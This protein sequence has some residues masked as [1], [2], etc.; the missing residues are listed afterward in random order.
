MNDNIAKQALARY[1]AAYDNTVYT[2]L[3][4]RVIRDTVGSD[5]D[6]ELHAGDTAVV[7]FMNVLIDTCL[8]CC[9]SSQHAGAH[10]LLARAAAWMKLSDKTT[11]TVHRYLLTFQQTGINA[12]DDFAAIAKALTRTYV[13]QQAIGE[14]SAYANGVHSWQGRTA[15]HLLVAAEYLAKSAELLLDQYD[16]NAYLREKLQHGLNRI[17]NALYEGVRHSDK[18]ERFD[19]N[20]MY[21]PTGEDAS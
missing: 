10:I 21:F 13:G 16:N 18:P 1:H 6:L 4:Q 9:G 11:D 2:G 3:R 5:A 12:A 19:F 7:D 14:A 15:Y 8:E 20:G 17:T